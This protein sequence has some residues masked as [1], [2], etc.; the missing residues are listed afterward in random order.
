MSHEHSAL[1]IASPSVAVIGSGYWGKNLVRNFAGIGALGTVCDSHPE[2]LRA[3]GEQYPQCRTRTSY[4]D[5]LR[6][7]SIHAVA[8]ATPAETHG[9]MV[10]EALIAGKDVFVEKPLCLSVDQGQTLVDLA[11]E[12]GRILMV[13]HLLWYHPA[14]LKLKELIDTGEL[15]RIQ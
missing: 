1:E 8:I 5:V 2:T 9:A 3:L 6:D 11:R 15:G 12:R 14:I 10:H 4:S 7:E 13:G